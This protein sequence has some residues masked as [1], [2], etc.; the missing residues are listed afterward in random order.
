[1]IPEM[2]V[3]N[4]KRYVSLTDEEFELFL[5]YWKTRK[6]KRK[7]LLVETGE[8]AR[9]QFYIISGCLRSFYTD[10]NGVEHNIQF[11][12]EDWWISDMAS[13]LS[14]KPALL[15]VEALEDSE[16]M[17]ID[18]KGIEELYNRIPKLERFFRLLLQ[19][20]FIAQQQRI[21][22]M[23]S[24]TAE[25]RYSEFISKYPQFEQR[26]PQVHV[27]SYLGITPEFLS[28]LRKKIFAAK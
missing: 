9:Y 19:N 11:S 14:Q 6:V 3:K 23:I 10:A 20:A 17:Q 21:L 4:I 8:I 22:S 12:V 24:K 2:L 5:S 25:E 15:T 13:F 1:M 7:Q 28:K 26:I 18:S 27:A 16:V